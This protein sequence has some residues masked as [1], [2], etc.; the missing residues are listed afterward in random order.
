[1]S[2]CVLEGR[3]TNKSNPCGFFLAIATQEKR[4]ETETFMGFSEFAGIFAQLPHNHSIKMMMRSRARF[5]LNELLEEI[6]AEDDEFVL[7][8]IVPKAGCE[9]VSISEIK[10]ELIDFA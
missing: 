5:E 3:T 9:D 4:G 7:V 1:M 10:I 2:L 6:E 8:K